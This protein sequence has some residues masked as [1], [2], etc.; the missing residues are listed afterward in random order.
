[1]SARTSVE[2]VIEVF[3]FIPPL[4]YR[5]TMALYRVPGEKSSY[6]YLPSMRCAAR[7]SGLYTHRRRGFRALLFGSLRLSRKKLAEREGLLNRK[8]FGVADFVLPKPYRKNGKNSTITTWSI[9]LQCSRS[10]TAMSA[11]EPIGITI[12]DKFVGSSSGSQMNRH[13]RCQAY[14]LSFKRQASVLLKSAGSLASSSGWV[15]SGLK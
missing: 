12:G 8:D 7:R 13:S 4:Y 9:L 3:S 6:G 14:L 5:W 11:I 1:M 15:V 10:K 2:S